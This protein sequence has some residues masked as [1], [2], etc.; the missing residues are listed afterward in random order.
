[1]YLACNLSHAYFTD[2]P[3]KD[4]QMQACEDVCDVLSF[5][6]DNIYITFG[7]TVYSQT[8]VIPMGTNCAPL[9]VDLF[10]YCYE[11]DFTAILSLESQCDII[12]GLNRTF[13]Y[14]N[15]ILNID[16]PLFPLYWWFRIY[17]LHS[18]LTLNKAN[19]SDLETPFLD[20]FLKVCNRCF[21]AKLYD[22]GDDSNFKLLTY[23][24]CLGMY[25]GP[26]HS[27]CTFRNLLALLEHAVNWRISMSVIFPSLLNSLPR[28]IAPTY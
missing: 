4:F 28:D 1:M 12:D 15:D 19:L 14:R 16:K 13:L 25:L 6:I 3:A 23:H 24:S 7:N 9:I 8:V 17:T 27:G 2:I 26:P 10:I 21:S 20:L 5:L 22:K 18:L 11:R